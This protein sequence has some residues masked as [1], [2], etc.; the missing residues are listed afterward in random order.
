MVINRTDLVTRSIHRDC[1]PR[2]LLSLFVVLLAQ[3]FKKPELKM[4]KTNF[5]PIML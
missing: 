1:V 4:F 5:K 2:F 3:L